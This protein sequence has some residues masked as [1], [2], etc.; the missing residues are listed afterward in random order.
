M[1]SGIKTWKI[2]VEMMQLVP[3]I[4]GKSFDELD[5]NAEII[6]PRTERKVIV[7]VKRHVTKWIRFA[8]EN[9]A[10]RIFIGNYENSI[11]FCLQT[12][13]LL[14]EVRYPNIMGIK[15]GTNIIVYRSIQMVGVVSIAL[16]ARSIFGPIIDREKVISATDG[17]P[18]SALTFTVKSIQIITHLG[19][20]V[21]NTYLLEL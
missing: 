3:Y 6:N 18:N 1:V 10:R 19:V 17:R 12:A 16:S 2:A 7:N 14:Y 20:G 4:T 13:K 8:Y 15:P 5:V 9:M 11:Q 21:L